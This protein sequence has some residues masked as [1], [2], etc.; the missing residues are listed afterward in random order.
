MIVFAEVM[1]M[2]QLV[3]VTLEH[4]IQLLNTELASGL[5]VSTTVSPFA[6]VVLHGTPET[7]TQ[8]NPPTSENTVPPPPP[9]E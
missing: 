5:A 4:P 1:V 3:S 2:V 6:K 9:V 7:M 8:V